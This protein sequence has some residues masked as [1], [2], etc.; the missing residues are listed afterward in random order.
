MGEENKAGGNQLWL[1]NSVVD[2]SKLP[3]PAVDSSSTDDQD[4]KQDTGKLRY[5]LVPP[6]PIEWLANVYTWSVVKYPARS[7]E[8]GI[9][10]SRIFGAAMRHLWA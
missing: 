1:K 3:P 9:S 8:K 10:W 7:W 4:R 6:G 2:A 5:D